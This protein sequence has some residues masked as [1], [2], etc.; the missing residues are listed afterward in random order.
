M[1]LA[2]QK[3]PAYRFHNHISSIGLLMMLIGMGILTWITYPNPYQTSLPAKGYYRAILLQDPIEK[4]KTYQCIA[5]VI[6]T[7][8]AQYKMLL[9]IHKDSTSATLT[10]SDQLNIYLTR[11][12]EQTFSYYTKQ[13]IFSSAYIPQT[14]WNIAARAQ[15]STIKYYA[16]QTKNYLLNTLKLH[17]D[18]ANYALTSAIT[19]G[20][21]AKLS[22]TTKQYFSIS[23]ASHILAVSGLHVG[24]IFAAISLLLKPL[25]SI[26]WTKKLQQLLVIALLWIYAFLCGLPPS[27]VRAV[28]MFS[29]GALGVLTLQKSQSLNNVCFTA[30]VMLLYNPNYL[31]DMGFQLSFSAV[32]GI[33]LYVNSQ[34]KESAETKL[35]DSAEANCGFMS[36]VNKLKSLRLHRFLTWV[37]E[38]CGVS[39]AAQLATLPLILYY[40]GSFPTYFLLTNLTVVPLGTLL[41]YCCLALFI[42]SPFT[43]VQW[44]DYPIDFLG[45]AMQ[46]ITQAISHLPLSKISNLSIELPQVLMLYAVL[47][48]LFYFYKQPSG[49][50]LNI[51][52]LLVAGYLIASIFLGV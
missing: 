24:I 8:T 13:S 44:L 28:S 34:G 27:I 30:F 38:M 18:S 52:L 5:H 2:V 10:E 48:G 35:L 12:Q 40:F 20:Q 9:Y 45:T 1:L 6:G 50:R 22:G 49:R 31:F 25:T 47:L 7:D 3:I 36:K 41:I 42:I 26:R 32:I 51:L 37:K 43:D 33:L 23:G 39:I 29:V 14:H 15:P 21:K 4:P 16:S 17:T 11:A 19:L 46:Y